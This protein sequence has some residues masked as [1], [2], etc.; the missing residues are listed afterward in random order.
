[1]LTFPFCIVRVRTGRDS[2]PV[3]P[4][5]GY[6]AAFSNPEK[7]ARY[8]FKRG[9]VEWR[10]TLVSRPTLAENIYVLK[11][12]GFDGL[13]IDPANGSPGELVEFEKLPAM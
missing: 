4:S 12:L 7:A 11:L 9:D 10:T 2:F 1:M 13:A 5:A 8:M 3:S 6:V